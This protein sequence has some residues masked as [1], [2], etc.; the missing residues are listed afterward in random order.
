[1]NTFYDTA[2]DSKSPFFLRDLA[3]GVTSAG[4]RNIKLVAD[5]IKSKGFQI[6][7]ENT[8]SLYLVPPERCFQECD[9]AYDSGNRILKEEYWSRMVNISIKVMEKLHDKV[10]DFLKKDNESSYL[11]MTYEKVLFLVVFTGKKKYYSIP[12]ESKLNF[13][14]KPFIRRV[15]II[16]REKSNLFRK[17][18]K[19][20]MDEFMRVNNTCT[21]HQIV[22]DVLKETV[23]DISQTDLNEIIK[24]AVWK[25]N[26]NN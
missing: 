15:E 11:K 22:E 17:I 24:T 21:L 14:K 12:H 13:N 1:M 7:Y 4:Q 25:L 20:I 5:F 2:G 9:E 26:K 8:D 18:G 16:K 3:G 23:K 6:K 19:C 10:N